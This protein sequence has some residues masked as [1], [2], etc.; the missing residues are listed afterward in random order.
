MRFYSKK[1]TKSYLF[2]EKPSSR[3]ILFGNFRIF[4]V[5]FSDIFR[6]SFIPI[7]HFE[8][9]VSEGGFEEDGEAL[10]KNK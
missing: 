9:L 3:N 8:C 1:I 6:P 10:I 5:K 7:Y 2:N 4:F